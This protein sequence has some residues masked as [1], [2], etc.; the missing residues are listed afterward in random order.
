WCWNAHGKSNLCYIGPR[1]A[2]FAERARGLTT[3]H[4]GQEVGSKKAKQRWKCTTKPRGTCPA[5]CQSA[6]SA[7]GPTKRTAKDASEALCQAAGCHTP[8]GQP[9]NCQ[10][11][12]TWCHRRAN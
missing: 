2:G 5:Q 9:H 7:L 12:H 8:G 10:C 4:R 6:F 1:N 3:D 11:G